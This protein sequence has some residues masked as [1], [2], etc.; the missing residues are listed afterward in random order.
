MAP[1]QGDG[2]QNGPERKDVSFKNLTNDALGTEELFIFNV[3]YL[4]SRAKKPFL[5]FDV[6]VSGPHN[7]VIRQVRLSGGSLRPPQVK[8]GW[9]KLDQALLGAKSAALLYQIV[10]CY[11]EEYQLPLEMKPL[12]SALGRIKLRKDKLRNPMEK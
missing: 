7:I 11:I 4:V 10:K 8:I 9:R 12:K 6:G 3:E 1:S 5:R 2:K